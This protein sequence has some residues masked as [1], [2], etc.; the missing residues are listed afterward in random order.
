VVFQFRV[1]EYLFHH[2]SSNISYR[3][4]VN[5]SLIQQPSNW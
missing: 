4:A 1:K 2:F 3:S 5:D